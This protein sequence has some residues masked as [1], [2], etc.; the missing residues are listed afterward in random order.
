MMC[1]AQRLDAAVGML[2]EGWLVCD[3]AP[4]R[5]QVVHVGPAR[6]GIV[7]MLDTAAPA[8]MFCAG[9]AQQSAVGQPQRLVLDRSEDAPWQRHGVRP[10]QALI[11]AAGDNAAPATR[12]RS[13]TPEQ[14]QAAIPRRVQDG[15]PAGA[16]RVR[17]DRDRIAPAAVACASSEPD[18]HIC[19]ALSGTTE[20]GGD[21]PTHDLSDRRCVAGGERRPREDEFRAASLHGRSAG[22]T[23]IVSVHTLVGDSEA[24]RR[25]RATRPDQSAGGPDAGDRCAAS[26][27][28]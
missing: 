15:I 17:S 16:A 13:D 11:A 12:A 6:R 22:A 10:T 4:G 19:R 25:K 3:P 24:M 14:Q 26:G 9:W 21:P 28:R 5:V 20:P 8:E 2:E 1:P 23:P 18:A 27:R 7:G